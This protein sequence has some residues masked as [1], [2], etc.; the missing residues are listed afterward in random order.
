MADAVTAPAVRGRARRRAAGR[1]GRARRVRRVRALP[2]ALPDLPRHRARAAS[3]PRGRIA[4][5]RAVEFDG[6]PA[7]RRV[8]RHHRD[9]RPVPWAAR[10]RARRRCRSAISSRAP[11]RR[12]RPRRRRPPTPR[13]DVAPVRGVDRVHASCSRATGC[14]SRATWVLL[15]GA[16][17]APRAA[18]ARPARAVGP[19]AAR[20]RSSPTT[21]AARRVPA[22]PGCVMDAWQRDVHR[23]A[24]AGDARHRRARRATRR[25]GRLLRRAPHPRRSRSGRPAGWPRRVMASMPGDGTRRRRQRGLRRGDEGL[26]AAARHPGGRTRSRRACA[27]SPNGWR[28]NPALAAA[29]HRARPWSSRT[30]ATSATSSRP[31]VRCGRCSRPRTGCTR[32]PTTACA[33]VPAAPT[34]CASAT[35]AG[36][37][38]DRKV[39]RA[40]GR[41]R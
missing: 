37:I 30:R 24:L 31:R 38:R 9:V 8:P 41:R 5:M 15:V 23:A 21:R 12:W 13:R 32:P 22:S 19:L 35:L 14:C 25:R 28:R 33:A 36:E 20:P 39:A 40:A 11:T 7:R 3:S 29:R 26:R 16:A 34:R 2:A 18:P 17:P 27:T 1:R 10:P 4:A 6:A